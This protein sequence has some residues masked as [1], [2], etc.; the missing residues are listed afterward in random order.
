[1][2]LTV[3]STPAVSSERATKKMFAEFDRVIGL[4]RLAALH[5]NDS[6]AAAG[7]RVDR[8]EHT[9]KGKI[10]LDATGKIPPETRRDWG[11]PIRMSEAVVAEVTRKWADYG[12]S[13]SGRPI[14]KSEP[15]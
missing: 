8:H 13:G 11:R 9:G 6:K 5:L 3:V 12:L 4:Q 15:R 14:W 10:G 1:M 2:P 7:S